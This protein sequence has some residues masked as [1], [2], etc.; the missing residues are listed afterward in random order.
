MP[1]YCRKRAGRGID[2]RPSIRSACKNFANSRNR[3]GEDVLILPL[4]N[5]SWEITLCLKTS[6]YW[7]AWRA[8]LPGPICSCHWL[9]TVEGSRSFG[10]G[11]LAA[12]TRG[13]PPQRAA[14][15]PAHF[16]AHAAAYC[17]PCAE[18]FRRRPGKPR[19]V[20][21]QRTEGIEHGAGRG[22]QTINLH[23]PWPW[24][25]RVTAPVQTPS[26]ARIGVASLW[27]P[28]RATRTQIRDRPVLKK[29]CSI[30]CC[31]VSLNARGV[32]PANLPAKFAS[33]G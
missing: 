17:G 33:R 16:A 19:P 21:S 26:M 12:A 29:N 6:S 4:S 20:A 28:A 10:P 3:S 31:I 14:D 11:Q 2:R 27:A 15:G 23:R 32:R 5:R 8:Y 30:K 24:R 22:S 1:G 18:S 13:D 25:G 9:I 7:A